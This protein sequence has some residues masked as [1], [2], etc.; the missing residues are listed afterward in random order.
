[1]KEITFKWSLIEQ[2]KKVKIEFKEL[3][4]EQDANIVWMLSYVTKTE[5]DYL[6]MEDD[7]TQTS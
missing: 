7:R 4:K 3:K 6:Q 2:T 1:M 5:R